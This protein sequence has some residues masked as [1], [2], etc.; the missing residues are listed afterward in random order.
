MQQHYETLAEYDREGF[1]II[2]DKTWEDIHPRQCF[3]CEGA[4]MQELLEKINRG[5][6]DWFMLRVRV[7][8]DDL[9]LAENYLGGCCYEDAREVLIDGTA[10]DIIRDTMHEAKKQLTGLA[11]KFTLMAIKHA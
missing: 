2:V 8:V 3:D 1:R 10:E 11:H 9:K 5:D 6:L 4:E 7:L